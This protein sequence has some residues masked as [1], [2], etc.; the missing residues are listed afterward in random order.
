MFKSFLNY[1]INYIILNCYRY[2]SYKRSF[3]D[4]WILHSC[5]ILHCCWLIHPSM[6]TEGGSRCPPLQTGGMNR[7]VQSRNAIM[8]NLRKLQ[9][10]L[11]I[12][13]KVSEVI[14]YLVPRKY[15][16]YSRLISPGHRWGQI[17]QTKKINHVINSVFMLFFSKQIVYV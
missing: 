12:S 6:L 13:Q 1:L 5:R 14:S 17:P 2:D 9:I 10:G 3:E 15:L 8:R 4:N 16:N 7:H 11:M